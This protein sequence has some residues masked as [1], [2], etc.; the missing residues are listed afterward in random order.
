MGK[1]FFA[2]L[3][4]KNL[5]IQ[6]YTA[7]EDEECDNYYDLG[8]LP[9]LIHWCIDVLSVVYSK[10]QQTYDWLSEGAAYLCQ[11]TCTY[12]GPKV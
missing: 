2:N 1:V 5:F 7:R 4:N 12:I 9:I 11:Q 10:K 3:R 6:T 8:V